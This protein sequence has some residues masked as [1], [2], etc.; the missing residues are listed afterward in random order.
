MLL[1]EPLNSLDMKHARAMMQQLRRAADELGR[2]IVVVLHDVNFASHY[3]D[4]ICAVKDGVVAEF[5]TAEE[6]MTDEVLSRIFDTPVQ[7]ID[8]PHGRL[9]AYF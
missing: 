2:T 1:D 7:V 5:G 8:G 3:A 6:I 9:A 4:W